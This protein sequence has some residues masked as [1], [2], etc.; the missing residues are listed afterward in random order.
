MEKVGERSDRRWMGTHI[1]IPHKSHCF[2]AVGVLSFDFGTIPARQG[3]LSWVLSAFP[4]F[5]APQQKGAVLWSCPVLLSQRTRWRGCW[6]Y[7]LG[8]E[9]FVLSAM[10]VLSQ[11]NEVSSDRS[12]EM[13]SQSPRSFPGLTFVLSLS[14][15]QVE[16]LGVLVAPLP[17]RSSS[18]ARSPRGHP[19]GLQEPWLLLL[20]AYLAVAQL[21][22]LMCLATL[23]VLSWLFPRSQW[24]LCF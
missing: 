21:W 20:P 5:W 13:W 16:R 14:G 4:G 24:P 23:S 19:E 18:C 3:N 2:E 17:P 11:Y 10:L 15:S 9:G 12:P 7:E 6:R 22:G 1:P 8:G